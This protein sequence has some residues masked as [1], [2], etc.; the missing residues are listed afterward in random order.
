MMNEVS[1]YYDILLPQLQWV[2]FELM[3]IFHNP[4]ICDYSVSTED[5]IVKELIEV[6]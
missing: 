4:R 1:Y 6:I 5:S 2:N 3:R